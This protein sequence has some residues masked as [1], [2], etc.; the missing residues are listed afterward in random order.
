MPKEYI[1]RLLFDRKHFSLI[2]K[3]PNGQTIGGICFRVF[4]SKTFVELVFM[5][6]G[7]HFKNQGFGTKLLTYF[8]GIFFSLFRLSSDK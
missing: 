5:A 8:K 4:D 3:K 1:T 6:I 7:R 2:L